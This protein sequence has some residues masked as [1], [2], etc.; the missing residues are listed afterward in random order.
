MDVNQP[1]QPPPLFFAW[2][3]L[4]WAVEL[5][6]SEVLVACWSSVLAGE[7]GIMGPILLRTRRV[8]SSI[9]RALRPQRGKL[10]STTRSCLV[11]QLANTENGFPV[12]PIK[13]A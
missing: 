3:V 9:G 5:L 4:R 8:E 11:G 2:A 10:H 6:E 12:S 7:A 1:V 13:L